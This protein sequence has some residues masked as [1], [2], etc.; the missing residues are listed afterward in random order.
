MSDPPRSGRLRR[1][2][3]ARRPQSPPVLRRPAP[4]RAA[5]HE[6]SLPAS[7]VMDW[8]PPASVASPQRGA[9]RGRCRQPG[10]TLLV[11]AQDEPG[12]GRPDAGHARQLLHQELMEIVVVRKYDF[13]DEI[14][15]ARGH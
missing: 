12:I 10:V 7:S 11:D 2:P 5:A 9:V 3:P 15:G 4:E 1:F 14:E 13:Y 8:L 6:S